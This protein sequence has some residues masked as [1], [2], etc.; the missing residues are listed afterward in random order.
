MKTQSEAFRSK[1][2]W[3]VVR[4]AGKLAW[5]TLNLQLPRR[6]RQ[7]RAQGTQPSG[8]H[9][10]AV[11]SDL[12]QPVA[13]NTVR[14]RGP[15]NW[16]DPAHIARRKLF[17]AMQARAHFAQG[18]LLDLGCGEKP[19]AGLFTHVRQYIGL[20]ISATGFVDVIG[21]GQAL[22]FREGSFDTVVCNEVLEHVPET[23]TVMA[24]IFRVLKPGGHLIATAPQTWGL[25][26]V[27]NDYYRFTEYGLR[28]L[29]VQ[30]GFESVEVKPTCGLWATIAQRIA[31]TVIYTY[32]P[33][34]PRSVVRLL[35]LL[36]APVQIVGAALDAVVGKR[37]DTLDNV[38]VGTR[39]AIS[40]CPRQRTSGGASW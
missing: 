33:H 21:D 9:S 30:S 20:D 1:Q 5:W 12:G 17:E 27:P 36:L 22:P 26:M 16:T 35:C 11:S 24:E 19:Y 39:R 37:G 40:S 8:G 31:D 32:A 28:Y 13:A 18:R 38:L 34:A 7:R 10:N 25:H 23:W 3:H 2:V 15:T 14:P 4:R 29:A 6:L